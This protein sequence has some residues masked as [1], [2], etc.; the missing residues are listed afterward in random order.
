MSSG[1]RII[2]EKKGGSLNKKHLG[3][4]ATF[5]IVGSLFLTSCGQANPTA[6]T[7]KPAT[8]TTATVKPT[9]TAPSSDKPQYGG[10]LTIARTG[11]ILGFDEGFQAVFFTVTNHMTHDE[12]LTG[13][14]AKGPGG[15]NDYSW[16]SNGNYSWAS[17]GGSVAES[18]EITAPG[19]IVLHIRQGIHF[20]LNPNSDAS[21]L[22][23]GRQLTGDDV[24]YTM[25][26]FLTM[27]TSYWRTGSPTFAAGCKVQLLDPWTLEA[28]CAPVD[29]YSFAAYLVDWCSIIPQEVINK[30]GDMRDWKNSVGS[31]PFMLTDF[32]SNSSA[33]FIKNPNY[34]RTDPVGPGKGNQLPYVDKVKLLII[35]DTS[36]LHSAMRTGKLDILAMQTWDDAKNVRGSIDGLNELAYIPQNPQQIFMRTDKQ[37]KPYKDLKVRQA[38]MYATDFNSI[39]TDFMDN[40]AYAQSFPIT[41]MPDFK[42]VYIPL[43]ELPAE[44]QDLYKYQPDKAK[45][46]LAEAGYPDGFQTNIMFSST[47]TFN[48]DYLS[49]IKDMWAKVNV[50]LTL[51]PLEFAA[52]NTRWSQRNYDDLFYG[53]MASAGTYRRATNFTGTGVGYNLSYI[54][55]PTLVE[56]RDKMQELFNAGDDAGCDKIMRDIT[57]GMLAQAYVIPTP[58]QK[59]VVFWQAWIKGYHGE[60]SPGI[61]NEWQ[62]NMYLWIDQGLKQSMG[63]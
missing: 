9:T 34:W 47:G 8:S 2:K 15:T 39:I 24:L 62:E 37:D 57:P 61:I 58:V 44:V 53:L 27:P 20:G 36:T 21:K 22:V 14:W 23:A 51:V 54:N 56:A 50:N 40:Q 41:P 12:P 33:Q 63:Y 18:Y 42:S 46:L 6:T 35:A 13:D 17:K 4:I 19:R 48:A 26:R 10:S 52:H 29:A 60:Q 1:A 49:I 5:L 43:E 32:V 45:A 38:L 7:S 55:D 16:L 25:N 31:G 59:Q 30:Y 11:D 28:T 3:I